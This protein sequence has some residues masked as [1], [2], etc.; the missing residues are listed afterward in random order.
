MRIQ[1]HGDMRY[2]QTASTRANRIPPCCLPHTFR[3]LW[4][5]LGRHRW[6]LLV[7]PEKLLELLGQC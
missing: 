2:L 4:R 7:I 3:A 6:L 5:Q 1:V